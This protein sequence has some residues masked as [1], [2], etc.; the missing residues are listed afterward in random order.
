MLERLW[1]KG[2]TP[3]WLMGVQ[4]GTAPLDS[5]M[6]ISQ[7]PVIP[8][9]CTFPKDAQSYHKDMS[10]TIVIAALF[11]IERTW[12][13]PKCPS[14]KEWIQKMGYIFTVEYYTAEKNDILKY[15]GKWMDL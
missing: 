3:M 1:G 5:S 8:F 15:A 13:Q 2:N 12:K 7:D 4:A 9:L 6:A 11:V 10:S 14:T